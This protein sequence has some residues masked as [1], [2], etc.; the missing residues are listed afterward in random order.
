MVLLTRYT[1]WRNVMSEE[2]GLVLSCN[3]N[4]ITILL[5]FILLHI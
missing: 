2:N 4:A 1:L 3:K 5:Y